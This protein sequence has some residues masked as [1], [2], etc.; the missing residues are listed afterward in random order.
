[1]N[2]FLVGSPGYNLGDDAISAIMAERLMLAFPEA[3]L[4]IAT[5]VLGRVAVPGTS[6]VLI[7]RRKVGGWFRLLREIYRSDVV[8][9]GGGTL[10][11]DA[12]GC[13]VIRGMI[14]FIWQVTLLARLMRKMV[15]TVPIGVDRLTTSRGVRWGGQILRRCNPVLL[16]DPRAMQLAKKLAPDH[17]ERYVASAD[18]VFSLGSVEGPDSHFPPYLVLSYVRESRDAKIVE[19]EVFHLVSMLLAR[20]ADLNLVLIAMEDREEDELG[21]FRH[22]LKRV[23]DERVRIEVPADFRRAAQILR[24]ARAVIAM[25]LH[26]MIITLGHAPL[27]GISRTTKTETLMSQ[28][29]I[30][31][32]RVDQINPRLLERSL[33]SVIDDEERLIHQRD[34]VNAAA[35]HFEESLVPLLAAIAGKARAEVQFQE[36]GE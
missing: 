10:I 17:S 24:N 25:R 9:I 27:V 32:L 6:E 22:V 8:L 14:P 7:E 35:R 20:W 36:R 5:N 3:N 31:G 28:A 11:Q 30:V 12:L 21:I 2:I 29:S 18:P 15:A 1:M 19:E 23:A 33:E 13:G 16:R 4:V 26:A 34:F